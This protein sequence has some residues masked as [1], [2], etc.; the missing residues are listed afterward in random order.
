[1]ALKFIL[2]LWSKEFYILCCRE[3]KLKLLQK[4]AFNFYESALKLKLRKNIFATEIIFFCEKLSEKNL[5]DFVGTTVG[6]GIRTFDSAVSSRRGSFLKIQIK[7]N[8][9][10][11]AY[12]KLTALLTFN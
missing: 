11:T 1:M 4:C 10:E 12:L 5:Q 7:F 6:Q 9:F 8:D 3:K 2:S